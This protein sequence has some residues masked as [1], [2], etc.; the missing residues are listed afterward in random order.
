M[1]L[2]GRGKESEVSE[3]VNAPEANPEP[4]AFMQAVVDHQSDMPTVRG[5]MHPLVVCSLAERNSVKPLIMPPPAPPAQKQILIISDSNLYLKK[6]QKGNNYADN[7]ELQEIVST[8]ECRIRFYGSGVAT[9]WSAHFGKL[10]DVLK[11]TRNGQDMILFIFWAGS[12]FDVANLAWDD[13]TKREDF[14]KAIAK[15]VALKKVFRDVIV[16]S[17][18]TRDAWASYRMWDNRITSC[19]QAVEYI[20]QYLQVLRTSS[21][22]YATEGYRFIHEQK[23]RGAAENNCKDW[24][25]IYDCDPARALLQSFLHRSAQLALL[26]SPPLDWNNV[27]L[28]ALAA[29][30]GTDLQERTLR[31]PSEGPLGSGGRKAIADALDESGESTPRAGGDGSGGL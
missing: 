21:L 6:G 8:N 4:M 16:F 1:R 3:Q 20:S 17:P 19:M 23:R 10:A 25:H 14:K 26:M 30:P 22:L 28:R 5:F 15:I 2:V 31:T 27:Y 18:T 12:D 11:D 7:D 29:I 13:E 9:R 24:Y